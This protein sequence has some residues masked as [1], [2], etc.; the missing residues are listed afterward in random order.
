MKFHPNEAYIATGSADKSVR[1]WSVHDGN[2]VRMFTGSEASINCLAYHDSGKYLAGA[3]ED[4]K[5][6]IWDLAQGEVLATLDSLPNCKD[7]QFQGN[8]LA[9]CFRNGMLQMFNLRKLLGVYESCVDEGNFDSTQL[10]SICDPFTTQCYAKTLFKLHYMDLGKLLCLGS[11]LDMDAD[12][13]K[14]REEAKVNME[15]EILE[16]NISQQAQQETGSE[17]LLQQVL[18]TNNP[19]AAAAVASGKMEKQ[20]AKPSTSSGTGGTSKILAARLSQPLPSISTSISG[21]CSSDSGNESKNAMNESSLGTSAPGTVASGST[22]ANATQ[23]MITSAELDAAI[24]S[25][26][27]QS[28]CE[29]TES[30]GA[31]TI[32]MYASS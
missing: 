26:I 4:A 23:Q 10:P 31:G 1:L 14:A 15:A 7:L 24:A 32:T 19:A 21:E 27:D 22:S 8:M 28:G 16:T 18:Q 17:T 25:V 12:E 6:I 13:L 20:S 11:D 30:G 9:A 5:I 2:I 3:G 29:S